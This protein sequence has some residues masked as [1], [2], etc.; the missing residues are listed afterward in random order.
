MWFSSAV[1]A[2]A[3]VLGTLSWAG[4]A[5]AAETL[6]STATPRPPGYTRLCSIY[7]GMTLAAFQTQVRNNAR[8]AIPD[9]TVVAAVQGQLT[10]PIGAGVV[11]R[12]FNLIT[13][14][15]NGNKTSIVRL[16]DPAGVRYVVA[17]F[18]EQGTFV[19]TTPVPTNI[20]IN[21]YAF[22]RA[23]APYMLLNDLL[24]S[25]A[26][27]PRAG[28]RRAVDI[29]LYAVPGVSTQIDHA[30]AAA[31]E[32]DAA[33]LALARTAYGQFSASP[34]AHGNPRTMA[35]L[36][37]LGTSP[38]ISLVYRDPDPDPAN[39]TEYD[40]VRLAN[41]RVRTYILMTVAQGTPKMVSPG[42]CES[43]DLRCGSDYVW[44]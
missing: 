2:G 44:P 8:D 18:T 22:A 34:L 40:L 7:Q 26:A 11:V 41:G 6:K 28:C 15:R 23:L 16:D 32:Q 37:R 39:G 38:D 17:S 29:Q 10:P 35:T 27:V 21:L 25:D 1:L 31:P 9:A 4:P 5:S 12:Q 36:G 42:L 20:V 14:E 13:G 19:G 33:T 3:A 43:G 24:A 30:F